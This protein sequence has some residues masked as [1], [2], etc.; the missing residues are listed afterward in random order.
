MKMLKNMPQTGQFVAMWVYN[1]LLW[2]AVFNR[3]EHGNLVQYYDGNDG[4]DDFVPNDFPYPD[5]TDIE[6]LV[7]ED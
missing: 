7:Q 6:Y 1:N 2:A 4:D 3:D 5:I